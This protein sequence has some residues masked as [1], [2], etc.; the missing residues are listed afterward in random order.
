MEALDIEHD[1][2]IN[3]S[4]FLKLL[5]SFCMFEP[6]EL[7]KF[8][9]YCFDQDKA[10]FFSIEDLK[11]LMYALHNVKPNATVTGQV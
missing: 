8:C 7:L 2:E 6:F 3:Y 10:G 11:Q 9:F 4:D 1:G 5:V